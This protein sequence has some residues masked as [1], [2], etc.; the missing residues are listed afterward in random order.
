MVELQAEAIEAK[1]GAR[2][3]LNWRFLSDP[4][5]DAFP[6]KS[7]FRDACTSLTCSLNS[8]AIS[9]PTVHCP[10]PRQPIV[11]ILTLA[12]TSTHGRC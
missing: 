7:P 8:P 5:C 3:A 11:L 4:D 1:A 9:V 2:L 12:S 6:E 10:L